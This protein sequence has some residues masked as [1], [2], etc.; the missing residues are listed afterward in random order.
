MKGH[1]CAGHIYIIHVTTQRRPHRNASTPPL[2]PPRRNEEKIIRSSRRKEIKETR[3][4]KN[5]I[6]GIICI[7]TMRSLYM[8]KKSACRS[9]SLVS[10]TS[11]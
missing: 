5:H 2:Y 11:L 1:Y 6:C 8:H 4:R 7:V 9:R 3:K 10:C